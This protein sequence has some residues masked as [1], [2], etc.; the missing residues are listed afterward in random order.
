MYIGALTSQPQ[1]NI[2]SE[3]QD[4]PLPGRSRST[5]SADSPAVSFFPP[6]PPSRDSSPGWKRPLK[7]SPL[8]RSA[9]AIGL[10]SPYNSG[11]KLDY[12]TPQ[13]QKQNEALPAVHTTLEDLKALETSQRP[14]N[15]HNPWRYSQTSTEASFHSASE[16][17]LIQTATLPTAN[18]QGFPKRTTSV[19][20]SQ[21]LK[22]ARNGSKLSE[23]ADAPAARSQLVRV[24]SSA[25]TRHQLGGRPFPDL[26]PLTLNP[27]TPRI[28][29]LQP[30]DT[31]YKALNKRQDP[32]PVPQL[33]LVRSN[34]AEGLR[35]A[36]EI[37]IAQQ[38]SFSHRQREL[39]V[40]IV[41]K[42]AKQPMAVDV[43]DRYHGT[44]KSQHLILEDA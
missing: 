15:A 17:Q 21:Q 35:K 34:S 38:I 2:I 42:A 26:Q 24:A 22:S 36:A 30:G 19:R 13:S 43:Q 5:S 28:A 33:P 8:H 20:E 1:A 11:L 6:A 27:P 14:K 4:L 39:L 18:N 41:P 31:R 37:S 16:T 7:R 25:V 44:R 40:P 32:L 9:T 23:V 3:T 12:G 29:Q 10:A